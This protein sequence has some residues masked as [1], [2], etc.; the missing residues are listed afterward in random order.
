MIRVL[1]WLANPWGYVYIFVYHALA[2]QVLASLCIQW[3]LWVL[4]IIVLLVF[5]LI[6]WNLLFLFFDDPLVELFHHSLSAVFG[7]LSRSHDCVW[8]L[9]S[10]ETLFIVLLTSSILLAGGIQLLLELLSFIND[11]LLLFENVLN[12]FVMYLYMPFDD[13]LHPSFVR[14]LVQSWFER[15]GISSFF[16]LLEQGFW[17]DFRLF[18]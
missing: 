12:V 10:H 17:N 15:E 13:W 16:L 18:D 9:D 11:D 3:D 6:Y 5:I 8:T 14:V 4:I 7:N 1:L 2:H